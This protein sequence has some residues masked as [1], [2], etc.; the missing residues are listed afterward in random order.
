MQLL[1]ICSHAGIFLSMNKPSRNRSD[2]KCTKKKK[3]K[4]SLHSKAK[5]GASK[6][7]E[8]TAAVAGV[9]T[10]CFAFS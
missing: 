10:Y 9:S 5:K 8:G 2:D 3:K 4:K 1:H 7:E 6:I